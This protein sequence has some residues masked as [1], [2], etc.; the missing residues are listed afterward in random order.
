MKKLLLLTALLLMVSQIHAQQTDIKLLTKK[1]KTDVELMRPVIVKMLDER[2]DMRHLDEENRTLAVNTALDQ[3]AENTIEYKS[4]G[5]MVTINSKGKIDG[6]WKYEPDGNV[7]ITQSKGK[8]VKRFTVREIN[9]TKLHL[10][11]ESGMDLFL[12]A[13]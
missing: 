4:N 5:T 10:L 11:S 8:E 7:L 12:T 9:T 6:T 3:I 1:W 2:P 13:K